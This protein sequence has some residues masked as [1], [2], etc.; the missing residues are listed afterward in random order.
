M[1][2]VRTTIR[3]TRRQP[4]LDYYFSFADYS[5]IGID[6]LTFRDAVELSGAR[7][8][9]PLGLY[10]GQGVEQIQRADDPALLALWNT[11][12]KHEPAAATSSRLRP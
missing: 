2:F 9:Q 3:D 8:K 11:A 6:N 10:Q 1:E 5:H 12:E 7:H 4:K